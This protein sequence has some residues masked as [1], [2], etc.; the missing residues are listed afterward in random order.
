MAYKLTI[1]EGNSAAKFALWHGDTMVSLE[2]QLIDTP[3]LEGV[4]ISSVRPNSV[5]RDTLEKRYE[6]LIVLSAST[7]LPITIGYT[8]PSSLGSDR[9]AAAVG[10]ITTAGNC[11]VMVVDVGT[12]VTY[13]FVTSDGRFAGGNIAPGVEMRLRALNAFTDA[14]PAVQPLGDTPLLGFD[15][16]SAMRSGAVRGVAAEIDC[17]FNALRATHPSL[18][19]IITGGSAP[20]VTPFISS[21]VVVEP[22]L[23]MIGLK[24]IIDYNEAL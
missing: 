21:P 16:P 15:T 10:A 11:D 1:D 5:L 23:V 9:I 12:A 22:N 14:L 19:I 20:I 17:Y 18:K 7:P 4:I 2:P 13:D 6:R 24:R 8:T 3:A